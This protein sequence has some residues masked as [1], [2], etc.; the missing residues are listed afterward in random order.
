MSET[1]VSET[2]ASTT[3]SPLSLSEELVQ[4]VRVMHLL[5]NQ[6]T[7]GAGP[8]ARERAAHVLLFPLTRQ[9]PLRQGALAEL[10]HAD[11]STVSRHV[12]LL[13]DHGLVRRVADA[14]DGR[15]SRLV[16]TPDGEAVVDQMRQE[17]AAL[18][19]QVTADWADAELHTFTA[20]LHRLVQQLTDHLPTLGATPGAA[21]TPEKDR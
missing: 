6:S 16:V 3:A 13:V 15:A 7:S 8:E 5:K 19:A 2:V 18:F 1:A 4:L 17:R 11:P 20:Q 14:S 10:V 21:T 12:T 9:G